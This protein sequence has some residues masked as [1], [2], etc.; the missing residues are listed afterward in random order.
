MRMDGFEIERP[1]I[2]TEIKLN[3]DPAVISNP[4]NYPV[5]VYK[6][7]L[8][9]IEWYIDALMTIPG[10]SE[11]SR[12]RRRHRRGGNSACKVYTWG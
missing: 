5:K 12:S 8:S 2:P 6:Y 10:D 9:H 11:A 4:D 1:I 3:D 7:V